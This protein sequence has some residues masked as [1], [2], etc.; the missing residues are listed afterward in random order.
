MTMTNDQV[1]LS[2]QNTMNDISRKCNIEP[3]NLV[4]ISYFYAK[5]NNELIIYFDIEDDIVGFLSSLLV[6][7]ISKPMQQERPKNGKNKVVFYTD[8]FK[9]HIKI[10]EDE[11]IEYPRVIFKSIGDYTVENVKSLMEIYV[12]ANGY[13]NLKQEYVNPYERQFN[14]E[15]EDASYGFQPEKKGDEKETEER[16][17]KDNEKA[18][19]ELQKMG[20]TVFNEP[21]LLD[22]VD[23]AGCEEQ[24][25]DIKKMIFNRINKD[26]IYQKIIEKTRKK[27]NPR[28]PKGVLFYGPGGVGKTLSARI[29]ASQLGIPVVCFKKSQ[30]N[31]KWV[32]EGERNISKI[33]SLCKSIGKVVL[34]ID[35]LEQVG[36]KRGEG[37]GIHNDDF[38]ATL[39]QEIDGIDSSDG[40][41]ILG[42]TNMKDII[43]P[44]LLQRFTMHIEFFN[45]DFEG[46]KGIFKLYANHLSEE[47]IDILAKESDGMPGR[48]IEY[49]CEAAESSILENISKDSTS[50]EIPLPELET[51]L[52]EIRRRNKSSTNSRPIGFGAKIEELKH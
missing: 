35:E 34:F 6:V 13:M 43:D 26:K 8:S 4:D 18:K 12:F 10:P 5:N 24:K 45:P 27:P 22:W 30:V 48:A 23:L 49:C 36:R 11:G 44:P 46:R 40:I 19:A 33:F 28:L 50:E 16:D 39:L 51:Y 52:E 1:I 29:I 14:A 31:S 20:L 47:D 15:V 37:G 38:L 7:G 9:V 21:G 41:I 2:I 42:S 3:R 32:N 25:K 17:P